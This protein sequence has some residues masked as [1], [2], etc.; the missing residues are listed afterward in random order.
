M[1]KP[2]THC[3]LSVHDPL[4][5]TWGVHA[6]PLQKLPGAQSAFDEQVVLHAVPPQR[7]MPQPV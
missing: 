7:Y 5:A 2:L 4:F 3:E 6:V 1:Q